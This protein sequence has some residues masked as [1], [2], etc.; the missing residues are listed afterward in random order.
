MTLDLELPFSTVPNWADK[1]RPFYSRINQ[2]SDAS[3]PV[4]GVMFLGRFFS[5]QLKEAES[6]EMELMAK[7]YL[8]AGFL[9]AV[10]IG[11]LFLKGHFS[12][13]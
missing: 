11:L 8:L 1:V 9:A 7:N 2:S 4:T 12:G 13:I 6:P 5:F 3:C 10:V